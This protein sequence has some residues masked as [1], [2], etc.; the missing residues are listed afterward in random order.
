MASP[1]PRPIIAQVVVV[2]AALVVFALALTIRGSAPTSNVPERPI[3]AGNAT[4]TPVPWPDDRLAAPDNTIP[5]PDDSQIA[6]DITVQVPDDSQTAPD[7]TVQVPDDSITATATPVPAV[8]DMIKQPDLEGLPLP[9]SLSGSG[10]QATELIQL[11]PGTIAFDMWNDAPGNMEVWLMY[12]GERFDRLLENGVI[13]ERPVVK[14]IDKG[15]PYYLEITADGEWQVNV[16][17]TE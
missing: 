12:D 4:A 17:L 5:V 2:F 6:P 8:N 7:I 13:A 9:V 10:S 15:G 16:S 1:I 11:E 14:W 3:N